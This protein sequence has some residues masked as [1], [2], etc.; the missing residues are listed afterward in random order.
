MVHQL[1]LA[2]KDAERTRLNIAIYSDAVQAHRAGS[3]LARLLGVPLAAPVI[4]TCVIGSHDG[5]KSG[6]GEGE[7]G[8]KPVTQPTVL[9]S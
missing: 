3:A 9:G 1:N 2:L 5:T 6:T 8:G 4:P 7:S